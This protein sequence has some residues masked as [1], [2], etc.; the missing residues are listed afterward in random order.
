MRFA[1]PPISVLHIP[2]DRL[3]CRGDRKSLI[4]L[5]WIGGR[6]KFM[7]G[8]IGLASNVGR[9]AMRRCDGKGESILFGTSSFAWVA[10]PTTFQ[11]RDIGPMPGGSRDGRRK[12]RG[13]T[14]PRNVEDLPRALGR[15]R[16]TACAMP[17]CLEAQVRHR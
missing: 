11:Q 5:E 4:C 10:C 2:F 3:H 6:E 9:R 13:Q 1:F 12:V 17:H 16:P 14:E 15:G 8:A 7:S